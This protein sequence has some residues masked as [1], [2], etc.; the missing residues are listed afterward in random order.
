MVEAH[1]DLCISP[2]AGR[3][4]QKAAKFKL[5]G[6]RESKRYTAYKMYTVNEWLVLY[7]FQVY[8]PEKIHKHSLRGVL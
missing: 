1:P 5:N 6:R 3:A 4:R 7:I 2:L 8:T